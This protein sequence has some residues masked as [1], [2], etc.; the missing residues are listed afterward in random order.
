MTDNPYVVARL[1]ASGAD[2]HGEIHAAP[3]NDV[4]TP[5]KR[6]TD[7]ALRMFTCT[8]PTLNR[9]QEAMEQIGDRSLEAEVHRYQ[10]I[11]I[12]IEANEEKR[13]RLERER[14]QAELELGLCVHRLQE[15]RACNRILEE[16]VSDQH[17]NRHFPA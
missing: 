16:M 12:R 8:F 6:L 1:T 14:Q 17:I 5:P 9:V 2:Y 11:N 4:D 7:A 3:V 13:M 10:G 15:A